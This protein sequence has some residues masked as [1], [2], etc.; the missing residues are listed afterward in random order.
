MQLASPSDPACCR[1][2]LYRRF[3]LVYL[4]CIEEDPGGRSAA[5]EPAARLLRASQLLRYLARIPGRPISGRVRGRLP[6]PAA[7]PG[8]VGPESRP[9]VTRTP[10]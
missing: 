2:A 6:W 9:G 5:R 1:P 3:R 7:A 10:T 4:P 8:A